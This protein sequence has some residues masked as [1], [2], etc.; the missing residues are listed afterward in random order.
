ML[1]DPAVSRSDWYG[2][3]WLIFNPA[4]DITY[5]H[6]GGIPGFLSANLIR[7]RDQLSVTVLTNDET[8][9]VGAIADRLAKIATP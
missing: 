1:L 9:T 6:D 2:Y 4:A 3:G 5:Y 7:P 8:I